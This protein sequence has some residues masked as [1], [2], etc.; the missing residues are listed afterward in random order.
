MI[1]TI[2]MLYDTDINGFI[3]RY[4]CDIIAIIIISINSSFCN[5]LKRDIKFLSITE[6]EYHNM[7]VHAVCICF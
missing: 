3:A 2:L 4:S 1:Q 6:Q 7:L 5:N